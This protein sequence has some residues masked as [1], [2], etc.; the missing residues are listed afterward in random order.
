MGSRRPTRVQVSYA[1][2]PEKIPTTLQLL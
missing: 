1:A 2:I